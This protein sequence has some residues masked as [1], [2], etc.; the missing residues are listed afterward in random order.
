MKR[1]QE[2]LPNGRTTLWFAADDG[3]LIGARDAGS[4][5]NVVAAYNILYPL[6]AGKVGGLGYRLVM[7]LSGLV[8]GVLGTLSV[9][10]FWFKRPPRPKQRGS[11]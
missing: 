10:S 9:W 1:P 3:R 4:L 2:W 8:L 7:T 11:R 6:H 5:S